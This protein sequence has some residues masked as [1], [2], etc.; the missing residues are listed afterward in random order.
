M[1]GLGSLGFMEPQCTFPSLWFLLTTV[2]RFY[3]RPTE[4]HMCGFKWRPM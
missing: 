4:A 1:N 3:A 2:N